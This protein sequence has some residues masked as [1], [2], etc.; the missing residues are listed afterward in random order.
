MKRNHHGFEYVLFDLDGTLTASGSGIIHTFEY[1]LDTLGI[2]HLEDM[3][4]LIGPPLEESMEQFFGLK[5]DD[6]TEAIRIYRERYNSI[7]WKDNS[8]YDGIEDM[9]KR[10]KEKGIKLAVATSK[11]ELISEKIISYFGIADFF[12]T[13]CGSVPG[14][15]HA[16]SDVI[17]EIFTRLDIEDRSSVLMVGDR[18]QDIEGAHKM[19][20]CA[21]GVL[22]GYGSREEFEKAEADF[23]V[24]MPWDIRAWSL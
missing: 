15:R 16:K 4:C 1:M 2:A 7:G 11:P 17:N 3:N 19:G 8:L 9:L 5:G 18:K 6:K 24:E 20:I 23:V 13:I 14:E 12:D 22:Y 10:H 21:M